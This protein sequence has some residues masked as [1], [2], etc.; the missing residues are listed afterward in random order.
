MPLFDHFNFLAPIYDRVIPLYNIDVLVKFIDLPING[1]ILDAG[2]GTGRVA[3]ELVEYAG[4]VFIADLSKNMLDEANKK[5]NLCVV[6]SHTE[7]FPFPDD[8]FERVIMID[9]MHHVCDHQDTASEMWRVVKRGG[10]IIIEEPDIRKISVKMIAIAE[11]IALMRSH[12]INPLRIA[13]LFPASHSKIQIES[14][15][16]NTWVIVE[17]R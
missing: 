6:Q 1:W 3:K 17:K 13:N 12:F 11:K 2:G 10:K 8:S 9:A 15:G 7:K 16:P 5:G 14:D 4:Q